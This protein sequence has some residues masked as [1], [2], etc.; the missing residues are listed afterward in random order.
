MSGPA[1][2]PAHLRQRTNKTP[3]AA[4][5]PSSETARKNR[6]PD[7]PDR[8][9]GWHPLLLE[10]WT[11]VWRSPMAGE[12]L[13]ADMRGGLFHLAYLH[14]LFWETA[15]MG[16]AAVAALPKLAAEIRLQEV[17]FGLSP[18]DRRRLQWEVEKGEQAAERTKSRKTAKK[19]QRP[20]PKKDPRSVLKAV[21]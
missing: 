16:F 4:R 10:W 9:E 11:S 20:D 7:L 18:I 8:K 15:D 21:A 17:R 19:A 6:V 13:D 1:P 12:Y 2:K 3:G 14:Q 5:L